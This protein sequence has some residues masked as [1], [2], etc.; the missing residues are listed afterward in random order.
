MTLSRSF[1]PCFHL[2][3]YVY[4][5]FISEYFSY[6]LMLASFNWNTIKCRFKAKSS[7]I[8]FI[9]IIFPRVIQ[10]IIQQVGQNTA[11]Y[12]TFL[13]VVYP[14]FKEEIVKLVILL[15]YPGGRNLCAEFLHLK[16]LSQQK[17]SCKNLSVK[18]KYCK[19]QKNLKR[20]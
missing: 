10:F 19:F 5:Y 18:I 4:L 15:Q 6:D 9:L 8:W 7:V 2:T 3:W 11:T 1:Q 14:D 16:E 13:K 12:T 17:Q 20:D